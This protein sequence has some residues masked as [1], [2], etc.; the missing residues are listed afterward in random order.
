[1]LA[2]MESIRRDFLISELHSVTREAGVTGTVAVQARQ[3]IEETEWLLGLA[4]DHELIRGV[5][6]WVPL[7]DADVAKYLEILSAN[8][9]WKGIVHVLHDVSDYF[10]MFR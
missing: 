5:V 1:M 8:L 7:I 2:G 3:T 6:G 4:R 10:Y 9:T